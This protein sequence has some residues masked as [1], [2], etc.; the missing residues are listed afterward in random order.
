MFLDEFII[1]PDEKQTEM[2]VYRSSF[3]HLLDEKW[4]RIQLDT[5]SNENILLEA[6]QKY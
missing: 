2:D 4:S 1:K 3:E 5:E 6:I